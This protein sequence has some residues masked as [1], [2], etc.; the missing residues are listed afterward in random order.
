MFRLL[1][2]RAILAVVLVIALFGGATGGI[3]QEERTVLNLNWGREPPTIDPSLAG[4]LISIELAEELFVSLGRA[5]DVTLENEP[6]ISTWTLADDGVTYTFDIMESIP[7]VRFNPDSGEVEQVVDDAGNPRFVDANQ[8]AYGI[9]RTLD[10][11]TTGSYSYV[12]AIAIEGAQAYN[13]ADLEA[14]SEEE[15]AAL[16]DAVAVTV[17]DDYTL[18]IR[19][20]FQAAFMDDILGLWMSSAQPSWL[21]DEAGDFWIEPEN[22]QSYGP[23][24][25][26]EWIHDDSLAL[27]A[28]PFWLGTDNI[29]QPQIEE[30]YGIMLTDE[31]ASFANYEAGLLDVAGAPLSELDRI[32]ADPELSEQLYIGP[33]DG[34]EYYGYNLAKPPMDNLNLR[35]A[36]SYAVDRVA[37]VENVVKGGQIPARWF[38]MPGL[39]AAPTLETHPDLGIT[40]D[41]EKAQEHMALALEEMGLSDASE[42]PPITLMYNESEAHARKAEAAAQMWKDLLGVNVQLTTQEWRVFLQTLNSGD[43][44]QIFR[45]SWVLDY[46]D[47]SNF[48]RDFFHSGAGGTV[49]ANWSSEEFDRLV[50]EAM[51]LEDT[52]ARREL[53]AQAEE[54]L[55][56]RDAVVLPLYHYSNVSMTK[57]YVNRPYGPG[58]ARYEKWS[59][60]D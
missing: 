1:D 30:I 11:A 20:P 43:G 44:P 28:N 49:R 47:A 3:A 31:S 53:Y 19:A 38:S 54:I 27:I 34:T 41:P 18:E 9:M 33:G 56:V 40:Y 13:E 14:I 32:K 2:R 4:D 8:V 17:V 12:L 37:M 48:L 5:N 42:L 7:W 15:L 46:S 58:H 60:N 39:V 35:L 52:E 36:L 23:Y 6:G 50:D 29:P 57:P 22:I 24:A 10:P 16:R 51:L 45:A 26:K 25:L 59:F 55:V 21:I